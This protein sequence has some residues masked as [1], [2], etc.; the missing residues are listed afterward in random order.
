MAA[1][2]A[3]NHTSVEGTTRRRRT[4]RRRSTSSS[5][6]SVGDGGG[7]E[8][9]RAQ[10]RRREVTAPR[11]P[12]R[13]HPVRITHNTTLISIK[14]K[15][16]PPPQPACWNMPSAYEARWTRR[17]PS[18]A[19]RG[20]IPSLLP[21]PPPPPP[22]HPP[23]PPETSPT[24]PRGPARASGGATLGAVVRRHTIVITRGGDAAGVAGAGMKH[25]RAFE[26][27]HLRTPR[28]EPGAS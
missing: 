7:V 23:A 18:T 19:R 14:R 13:P 9:G 15:L 21:L 26:G 28:R 3:T 20:G 10:R 11:S 5:N 24:S 1:V 16:R 17:S 25:G 8:P 6:S 2:T 27:A 4:P 12:R 22:R